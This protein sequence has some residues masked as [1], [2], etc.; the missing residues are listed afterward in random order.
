[1]ERLLSA[2]VETGQAG[3]AEG[4]GGGESLDINVLL[5]ALASVDVRMFQ[6]ARSVFVWR[7]N[8]CLSVCCPLVM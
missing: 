1:M 7:S 2:P 8:D 5:P 6:A 3:E 4:G